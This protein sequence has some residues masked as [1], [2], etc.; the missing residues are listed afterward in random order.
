MIIGICGFIG[1]GKD[2]VAD[3]L[4]KQHNFERESFASSLKDAVSVVFGWDREM[5][6]GRSKEARIKRE[7]VDK[8]WAEK[9]NMPSLTPRWVLQYWGTEVARKSFHTDIWIHSLEN[10]LLASHGNVVITDCR[11][12]NEVK[13]IKNAGGSIIWVQRG[14][15][16]DWIEAAKAANNGILWGVNEMESREIHSSE[17]SWLNTEFDTIIDNNSD[18]ESL[19]SQIDDF[20]KVSD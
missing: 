14:I 2:T 6:E 11:F 15:L 12:S 13:S 7:E 10:K 19:Y 8:W 4:I 17:W 1:C 20:L 3:Y 9:L 5:L 18:L 16:P